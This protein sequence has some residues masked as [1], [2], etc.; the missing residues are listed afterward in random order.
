MLLA[1]ITDTHLMDG[2]VRAYGT[3]DT[4]IHLASAV[5]T[6]AGLTPKPDALLVAGDISEDGTEGSYALFRDMVAPLGIPTYVIPGN[7]DSRALMRAAFVADGYMAATGPLDYAVDLGPL[8][9]IALD[10]LEEGEPFGTFSADQCAWLGD[11]LAS[12]SG[13]P[14]IIMLHHPPFSTGLKMDEIGC[15]DGDAIGKVIEQFSNVES[16]L[17]GHFHRSMHRNWAGTTANICPSTA[18]QTGLDLVHDPGFKIFMEP[19]Q[20]QLLHWQEETGVC[21]H[22]VPVGSFEC[23]YESK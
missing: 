12:L 10:T 22:Q 18:H 11:T 15:R 13:K 5:S 23:V 21:V 9:L 16:V 1:E 14:A 19:P 17:A 6:I 7:H 4:R 8:T 2:G 3:I 20:I